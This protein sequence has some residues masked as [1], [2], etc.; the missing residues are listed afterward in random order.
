MLIRHISNAKD[1]LLMLVPL[2]LVAFTAS[3]SYSERLSLRD[4]QYQG[5]SDDNELVYV[6]VR[7][8]RIISAAWGRRSGCDDIRTDWN[9]SGINKQVKVL[10]KCN[11]L[12]SINWEQDYIIK[13]KLYN[14]SC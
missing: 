12:W 14:R 9:C 7:S 6:V 8:G 10:D 13:A 3:P 5:P 4:G 2:S 1:L 11:L